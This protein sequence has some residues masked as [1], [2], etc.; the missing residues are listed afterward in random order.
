MPSI[1]GW[2]LRLHPPQRDQWR[3]RCCFYA[4][5]IGL[6]FATVKA[7]QD[8]QRRYR[9]YALDIGLGFATRLLQSSRQT[10]L[11]CFYALD[12]GL[13]FAT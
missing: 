13:S 8:I 12:I 5:D 11:Q 2:A 9:F 7:G 1:S 4:L 10:A 6:G 3:Q